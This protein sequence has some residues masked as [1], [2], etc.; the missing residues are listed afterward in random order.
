MSQ[1]VIK[2]MRLQIFDYWK[3]HGDVPTRI[4]LGYAAYNALRAQA[5]P[6]MF[7]RATTHD[8]WTAAGLDL[9]LVHDDLEHV[10]VS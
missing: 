10:H 1:D 8:R 6:S 9:Y 4:Y 2:Q 3:T 5:N 7:D